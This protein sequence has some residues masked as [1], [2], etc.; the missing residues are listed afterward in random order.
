M[1]QPSREGDKLRRN[2]Q[3]KEETET[4]RRSGHWREPISE[5]K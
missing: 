5:R 1:G 2:G 3:I 4:V